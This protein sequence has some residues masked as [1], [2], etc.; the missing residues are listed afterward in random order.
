M[1]FMGDTGL[2]PTMYECAKGLNLSQT[3]VHKR[4]ELEDGGYVER[5]VDSPRYRVLRNPE[6]DRV[7]Q[8]IRFA[9]VVTHEH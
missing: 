2:S 3:T 5:A 4:V 1:R 7:H 9:E 8:F 6:G